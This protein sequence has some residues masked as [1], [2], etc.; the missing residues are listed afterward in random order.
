[1]ALRPLLIDQQSSTRESVNYL[2]EE[3]VYCIFPSGYR[4]ELTVDIFVSEILEPKIDNLVCGSQDLGLI[5]VAM[6]GIPRIPTQCR[7]LALNL[8]LE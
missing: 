1:M 7:E 3:N 8:A 4:L 2:W 5:H 6:E